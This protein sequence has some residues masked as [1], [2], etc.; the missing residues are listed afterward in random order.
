MKNCNGK[1]CQFFMICLRASWGSHSEKS[2]RKNTVE[3]LSVAERHKFFHFD[4]RLRW[5]ART[6]II[7]TKQTHCLCHND[8]YQPKLESD[9]AIYVYSCETE[10]C[11]RNPSPTTEKNDNIKQ[12]CARQSY[13][14]WLI[15]LVCMHTQYW[16]LPCER[17]HWLRPTSE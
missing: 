11:R 3:G 7:E 16:L 1:T 13:S 6:T 12:V 14:I 15:V 9:K 4:W 10:R 2:Y 8:K 5:N 17:E